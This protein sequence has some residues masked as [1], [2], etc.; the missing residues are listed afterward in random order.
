Y[1]LTIISEKNRSFCSYLQ[2]FNYNIG[3]HS[4]DESTRDPSLWQVKPGK[5]TAPT[6]PEIHHHHHAR[7]K[8][9]PSLSLQAT[10]TARTKKR[11][12]LNRAPHEHRQQR[13]RGTPP[14]HVAPQPVQAGHAQE[15]EQP[16]QEHEQP[17]EGPPPQPPLPTQHRGHPQQ[18]LG[19]L[20]WTA[21]HPPPQIHG[22]QLKHAHRVLQTQT[23]T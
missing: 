17:H 4:K 20:S 3:D 7:Q 11:K 12:N 9:Q 21:E 13:G 23:L 8:H 15:E 2:S 22:K 5:S 10:H 16:A 19:P 1:T 14:Q 18:Q 6:E